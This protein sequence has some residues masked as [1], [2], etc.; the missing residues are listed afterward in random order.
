[1][2]RCRQSREHTDPPSPRHICSVCQKPRSSRFH[3]RHPIGP[4][5]PVP[6]QGVCSRCVKKEWKAMLEERWGSRPI[7]VYEIH[8]HHYYAC[9][10]RQQPTFTRTAEELHTQP[11]YPGCAELEAE[12]PQNKESGSRSPSIP[13]KE[14]P[15]P[16]VR[17][18]NKP[19]MYT[20]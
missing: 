12:V 14:T 1:M 8:H 2:S 11:A 3:A 13:S 10:C 19:T 20:S 6:P 7:K 18:W 16:P 9:S 15:P 5:A 17:F 4:G